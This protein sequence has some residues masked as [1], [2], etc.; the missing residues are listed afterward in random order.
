MSRSEKRSLK[1]QESDSSI[2]MEKIVARM[3][4]GM[5]MTRFYPTGKR[6]PENR[7]YYVNVARMI[8]YWTRP[9]RADRPVEGS[10]IYVEIS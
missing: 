6:K 2:T 10:G 3:E 4:E 1:H 7:V 5:T 8:F 9:D